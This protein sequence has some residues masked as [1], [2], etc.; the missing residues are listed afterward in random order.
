VYNI[1]EN[2]IFEEEFDIMSNNVE[3]NKAAWLCSIYKIKEKIGKKI[4]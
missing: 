3:K 4:T 1:D 2:T